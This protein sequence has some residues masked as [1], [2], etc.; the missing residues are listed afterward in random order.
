MWDLRVIKHK[1]G[2]Q[3]EDLDL[4]LALKSHRFTPQSFH[5]AIVQD[6]AGIISTPCA[7]YLEYSEYTQNRWHYGE[8]TLE[9]AQL[10]GI[11]P[12]LSN[13]LCITL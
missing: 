4:H 10:F 1:S 6:D 5:S 8:Y 2:L 11:Y 7:R 13:C 3:L 9:I 12:G